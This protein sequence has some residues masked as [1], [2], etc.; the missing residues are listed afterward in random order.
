LG[1]DVDGANGLSFR[2]RH[3]TFAP[4]LASAP[5]RASAPGLG[6]LRLP[7][8]SLVAVVLLI[9]A[10]AAGCGGG[11]TSPAE[12]RRFGAPIPADAKFVEITDLVRSHKRFAGTDV[13][14][15]GRVVNQCPTSGC[16]VD[17][18]SIQG[19]SDPMSGPT[20]LIHLKGPAFDDR[21]GEIKG[22][23]P[24]KTVKAKAYVSVRGD[25][26]ELHASSLEVLD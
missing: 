5:D 7:A 16:W 15:R 8:L 19:E 26:A 1:P 4:D 11:G 22:V 2:A 6:I 9:A 25:R 23:L 10:L 14:I 12:G 17:V 21:I 20:I 24:G 3:R 18:V 13:F